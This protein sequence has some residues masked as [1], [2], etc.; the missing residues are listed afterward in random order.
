MAVYVTEAQIQQWIE[1]TKKTID[2]VDEDLDASTS[3]IV[4]TKLSSRVDT[5]TWI[6]AASTPDIIITILSMLIASTM[7]RRSFPD[8]QDSDLEYC[9][10]LERQAQSI[11]D[12]I[13]DGTID[14]DPSSALSGQPAFWPTDQTGS[15]QQYDAAGNPIGDEFSE[16]IK[17]TMGS[18]F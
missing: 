14:L 8:I 7:L 5:T 2:G 11:I 6:N 10:W 9:I 4:F 16:D 18:K 17:F 3:T 13:L 15:S 1:P 12:M